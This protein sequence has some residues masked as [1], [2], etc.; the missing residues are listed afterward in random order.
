MI[1]SDMARIIAAAALIAC[2]SPGQAA[3]TESKPNIIV[4][5]TDDQGYADLSCVGT[6]RD[7]QTPHL[8]R[9]AS[10]GVRFTN[11]YVTAPQ[12]VPSRAGLLTG[13]DQNRFGLGSN[14]HGPLP[15]EE[16]TLANRLDK[17]GYV[18]GMVGKWHLDPNHTDTGFIAREGR[19]GKIPP[20]VALRYH[21]HARGFQETFCG[22]MNQYSATYD[23]SGT[24]FEK[25]RT[26]NL[27][28]DRIDSQ[29]D[30]AL[31]FIDIH[32]EQPF[33]LYLA[34]FA[35]HVPMASSQK[36][37]GR[38]PGEMPERRRHALAMISSVD[39]GVGRLM[40]RLARLGIDERTIIFFISD[41]GAPLKLTMEDVNVEIIGADWNG[42]MN[43]PLNGEKGMLA[44]GGI[45]VPFL[46]RWKGN[47][48]GGRVSDIPVSSLDVAATSCA[49]AGIEA[50][51]TLDGVNLLPILMEDGPPVK[52]AL[53]WRFWEQ[54]AIR[55][56]D[57][58]LLKLSNRKTFLF[59]LAEDP[60][61]K[62]DLSDRHPEIAAR[63]DMR[64]SGWAANLNP[65]GLPGG[66]ENIQ[67]SYFYHHFFNLPL[68][69]QISASETPL[70]RQQANP[71]SN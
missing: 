47:C 49:L 67:E 27:N 29:T 1:E 4:I 6:E 5:F 69:D 41:N 35:P 14:G 48:P 66:E 17:A 26:V 59:N 2:I 68:P 21:P 43:T 57:W 46:V 44:E 71:P 36:Y 52:R 45:R 7:V 20:A 23:L 37:L 15:L 55:E 3:G 30:A 39:D 32:H 19:D 25:P 18:T 31:A 10:E 63:L 34:Y 9:L 38:F 62:H 50:P 58:K 51:A 70:L 12:C 54:S 65:P 28:G 64:L 40:E 24:R 13:R 22:Q 33:F 60:G 53:F 56:G 8:D 11:G 42:S 16:V 61:E